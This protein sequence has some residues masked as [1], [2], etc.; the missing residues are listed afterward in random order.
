MILHTEDR[1][2]AVAH[3]FDSVVIQVE[4]S[5]CDLRV[6]ERVGVDTEAVVLGS[7]F[8]FVGAVV[9]D[10]VIGSVMAELE[11]VGFAAEGEAENLM[12]ETDAED[13]NLT[14]EFADLR[15]LMFERFGV[16]RAVGEEDAGRFESENVLGGGIGGNDGDAGTDVHEVAEDVAFDAV[17]VSDD[18][19]ALFGSSGALI[20]NADGID[21]LG[22]LVTFVGADARH[23]ILAGHGG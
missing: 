23:K 19:K 11:L 22:P 8:H 3:P 5:D 21:A 12:T 1:V 4:M 20:G 14:D 13:G 9:Y 10:G 2:T 17:I 18:V 15:G 7:D 6:G 16:S